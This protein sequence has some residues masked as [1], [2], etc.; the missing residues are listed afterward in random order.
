MRNTATSETSFLGLLKDFKTEI[1]VLIKQEIDLAKAE[2]SEKISYFGKN[3]VMLAI[4]GFV[5]YAG[6]I[7]LLIGLGAIIGYAFEKAGLSTTMAHFLGW[8]IMG[9]IVVGTGAMFIM[10]ALKSFKKETLVPEKTIETLRHAKGEDVTAKEPE[11][12]HPEP[13]PKLSSDTIKSNIEVTHSVL[14][15]TSEEIARRMSPRYMGHVVGNHV[16]TH[17]V[18]T[19]LI[20][21]GTGLAGYLWFRHKHNHNH[22]DLED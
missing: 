14:E 19:G 11:A 16:K 15:D 3:A 4:G 17:P 6:L 9:L 12:E 2:M 10:K 22:V 21:V 7:V 20:G 5:A 13:E 18:Q 1:V 8:T